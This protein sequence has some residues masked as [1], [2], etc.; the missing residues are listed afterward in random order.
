ME[1]FLVAAIKKR[2]ER[3]R[4]KNKTSKEHSIIFKVQNYFNK[5]LIVFSNK[6]CQTFNWVST[7]FVRFLFYVFFKKIVSEW[8]LEKKKENI[9]CLSLSDGVVELYKCNFD[10]LNCKTV[11]SYNKDNY[12]VA[13]ILVSK[14]I[15]CS[16]S[17][18]CFQWQ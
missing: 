12:K 18:H 17:F 15:L 6:Q 1:N 8:L 4:R 9:F 3:W 13:P 11:R 2:S 7:H 5:M 10:N 14:L 16:S